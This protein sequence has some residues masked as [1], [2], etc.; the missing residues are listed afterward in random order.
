MPYLGGVS[1][2]R[3][4]AR[5]FVEMTPGTSDIQQMTAVLGEV[6]APWLLERPNKSDTRESQG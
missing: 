1:A 6:S 2:G 3:I 5:S 4:S